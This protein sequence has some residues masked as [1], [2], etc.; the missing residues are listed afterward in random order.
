MIQPRLQRFEASEV[1]ADLFAPHQPNIRSV[2]FL[3]ADMLA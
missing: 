2:N 3:Q 1:I